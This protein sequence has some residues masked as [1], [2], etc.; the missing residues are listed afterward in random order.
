MID[1]LNWTATSVF[2]AFFVLVTVVGFLASR[3]R[4]ADLTQLHEW[5]LGGTLMRFLYAPTCLQLEKIC[6]KWHVSA[7]PDVGSLSQVKPTRG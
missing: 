7:G 4:A 1:Q 5:G 6:G 3:W 2:T